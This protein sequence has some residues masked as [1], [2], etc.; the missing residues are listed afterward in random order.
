MN[1]SITEK[2]KLLLE[3]DGRSKQFSDFSRVYPMATE[4]IKGYFDFFNFEN[5]DV[6]TVCSS[7]DHIFC[8]SVKGA[9]KIDCFDINKLTEYYFHF[10]KALILAY[11][12]KTFEEILIFNLIPMGL[13][14]EKWY[15][16]VRCYID[17][18]YRLF[19]DEIMEFS[20]RNNLSLRKMFLKGSSDERY[21]NEILNYF[22][23]EDFNLLQENL[24]TLSVNFIHS[25]LVNLNSSLEGSYDYMFLSNISDYLGLEMALEISSDLVRFLSYD[26]KIA[27]AYIY[28]TCGLNLGYGDVLSFP[29]IIRGVD[30]DL[31]LCL[32][33]S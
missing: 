5:K 30:N 31:V 22:N 16:K 14:K 18:P 23:E 13:F 26:G 27:Y 1:L 29:S 17:E 3:N 25:D 8:A 2:G 7:G 15:D 6:L 9:R 11:D 20:F 24:D 19:W 28:G 12:F 32:K 4:N 21:Y 10:K 33:K